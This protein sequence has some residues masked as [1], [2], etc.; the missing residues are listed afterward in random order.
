MM[1]QSNDKGKM[2]RPRYSQIR[3]ASA[4]LGKMKIW[5]THHTQTAKPNATRMR[6]LGVSNTDRRFSICGLATRA[7]TTI[8]TTIKSVRTVTPP[9]QTLTGSRELD[10]LAVSTRKFI[11]VRNAHSRISCLKTIAHRGATARFIQSYQMAA[12]LTFDA[13]SEMHGTASRKPR[14]NRKS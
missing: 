9:I 4:S 1:A 10:F 11:L 14:V 3:Y 8:R 7:V 12:V 6:S 5:M 2:A 13:R